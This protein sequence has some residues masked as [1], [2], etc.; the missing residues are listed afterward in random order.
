MMIIKPDLGMTI[1]ELT[2]RVGMTPRALRFYD[3]LGLVKAHRD[4]KNRRIYTLAAAGELEVVGRLRDAG[5][6]LA[7]VRCV[8][9]AWRTQG[10][11]ALRELASHYLEVRRQ[12]LA[13]EIK[14]LAA[15]TSW[16]ESRCAPH[17]ATV[18]RMTEP[19]DR[20][21]RRLGS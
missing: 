1:G 16:I 5:L 4:R 9:I 12:A 2:R 21:A 10:P 8:L 14:N 15:A 6:G 13:R 11:D 20:P 7:E 3:E 18:T 17:R 19:R